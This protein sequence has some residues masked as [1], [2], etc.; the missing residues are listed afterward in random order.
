[1]AHPLSSPSHLDVSGDAGDNAEA[2]D[3]AL[4]LC[5]SI[6]PPPLPPLTPARYSSTLLNRRLVVERDRSHSF[7]AA[8]GDDGAASTVHFAAGLHTAAVPSGDDDLLLMDT[9]TRKS[10]ARKRTYSYGTLSPHIS[11]SLSA[12][13]QPQPPSVPHSPAGA[14]AKAGRKLD[15]DDAAGSASSSAAASAHPPVHPHPKH[16]PGTF[17]PPFLLPPSATSIGGA[18]PARKASPSPIH[19]L[20][21]LTDGPRDPLPLSVDE[22]LFEEEEEDESEATV[23]ESGEARQ[24]QG[25]RGVWTQV[26]MLLHLAYRLMQALGMSGKW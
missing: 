9:A 8:G 6:Q 2:D 1:M 12:Q 4:A 7:T 19:A 14:L 24:W 16:H 15:F 22:V 10:S 17:S 26:S 25:I 11:P 23:E 18:G 13:T 5:V 20:R 21:A 3:T